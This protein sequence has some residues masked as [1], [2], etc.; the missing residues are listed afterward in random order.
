MLMIIGFLDLLIKM[1]HQRKYSIIMNSKQTKFGQFWK[2][3]G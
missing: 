2:Y 1:Y 3:E